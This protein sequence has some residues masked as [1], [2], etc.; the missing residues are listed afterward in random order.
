M[1]TPKMLQYEIGCKNIEIDTYKF[2]GQSVILAGE[3][4]LVSCQFSPFRRAVGVYRG[5]F[6]GS[7]LILLL[8]PRASLETGRLSHRGT[9]LLHGWR[10]NFWD[11]VAGWT[12]CKQMRG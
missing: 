4:S 7:L 11:E 2:L 9:G 5:S 8:L 3:C 1:E 12:A 6:F 10:L